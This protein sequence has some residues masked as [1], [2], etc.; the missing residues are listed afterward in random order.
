MKG[1]LEFEGQY[2]DGKKWNGKGYDRNGNII[3]ELINGNG[4]KKEYYDDDILQFEGE[5]LDGD[6]MER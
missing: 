2:E 6:K 4:F 5:Y 3:Y 1:K